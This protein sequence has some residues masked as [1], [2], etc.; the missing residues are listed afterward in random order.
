M[1][2]SVRTVAHARG[3]ANTLLVPCRIP[4]WLLFALIF[5]LLLPFLGFILIPLML[6]LGVLTAPIW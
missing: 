3:A 6:I 2:A 5:H 4:I 1:S